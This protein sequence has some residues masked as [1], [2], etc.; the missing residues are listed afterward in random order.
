[1]SSAMM[2]CQVRWNPVNGKLSGLGLLFA[3]GLTVY[4]VFTANGNKLQGPGK[5]LIEHAAFLAL[6]SLQ[7]MLNPNPMP[8]SKPK[9]N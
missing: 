3:A 9:T 1:M 8:S 7:I 2:F 6:G 4:T 5:A